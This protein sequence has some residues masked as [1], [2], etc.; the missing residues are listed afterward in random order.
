MVY[1]DGSR[2]YLNPQGWR[3]VITNGH[4]KNLS[5]LL[6]SHNHITSNSGV[7]TV[8][9][10]SAALNPSVIGSFETYLDY[11]SS[12]NTKAMP[13]SHS[14]EVVGI[15]IGANQ[16]DSGGSVTLDLGSNYFYGNSSDWSS[17]VSIGGGTN[18]SNRYTYNR[19]FDL[20]VAGFDVQDDIQFFITP[21]ITTRTSFD[22]NN[23]NI[24]SEITFAPITDY[25]IPPDGG[26][27]DVLGKLVVKNYE[28]EIVPTFS[29]I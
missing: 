19:E 9:G 1:L 18:S 12:S 28:S 10:F 25:S 3:T 14:E 7:P 26:G 22:G 29:E 21:F 24:S 13:F 5:S 27:D 6:S 2:N 4:T 23:H 16:V 17:D 20:D 15:S 8:E 11:D